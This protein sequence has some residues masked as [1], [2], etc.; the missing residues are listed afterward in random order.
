[1]IGEVSEWLKEHA[2]KA[3]VRR[4]SYLGFKSPSL[5]Q[6]SKVN[7]KNQV[8]KFTWFFL[9]TLLTLSQPAVGNV[10]G[11]T[12]AKKRRSCLVVFRNLGLVLL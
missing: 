3:C 5:R 10:F 6:L 11:F 1:M 7:K 9:L 8:N 12:S 2:W 4:E